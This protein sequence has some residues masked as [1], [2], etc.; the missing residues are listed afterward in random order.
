MAPVRM[1]IAA[2][3]HACL[4]DDTPAGRLQRSAA[5]CMTSTGASSNSQ[6]HRLRNL[7]PSMKPW[8]RA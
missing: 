1:R 7:R 2:G 6:L 8:R 5:A 3:A 4:F